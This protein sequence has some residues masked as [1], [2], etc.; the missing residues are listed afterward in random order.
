M[1]D[2]DLLQTGIN[3][4]IAERVKLLAQ[5][6]QQAGLDGIVC[7]AQEASDL[8]QLLGPDF[9]LVTPGIRPENSTKDDQ[10]RVMTPARAIASGASYLVIGRPI[11]KADDPMK[12]LS[13]ISQSMV[14]HLPKS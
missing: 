5:L 12:S 6:S 13:E 9:L 3:M 14:T 4:P 8:R 2:A 7:S 1:S 11:T 10:K